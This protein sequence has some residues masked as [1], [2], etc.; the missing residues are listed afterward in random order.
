MTLINALR[1]VV[2]VSML[3]ETQHNARIDSDPMFWTLHTNDH[4]HYK[5]GHRMQAEPLLF[6]LNIAT[7][8]RLHKSSLGVNNLKEYAP[9]P[10]E[11]I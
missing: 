5:Q 4:F 6:F 9:D 11:Y 8:R 1:Y 3:V 2:F 10:L 7:I